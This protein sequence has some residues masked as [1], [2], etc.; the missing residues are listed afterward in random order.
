[1]I[2]ARTAKQDH[3][4]GELT[5]GIARG[6]FDVAAYIGYLGISLLLVFE[7][8]NKPMDLDLAIAAHKQAVSLTP[9]DHPDKSRRLNSLGLSR[10]RR[11][12]TL[13]DIIDLDG[14]IAAQRRAMY[15]APDG[16]PDKPGCL[17]NLG[18]S[19]LRRFER[20]GDIGD[21]CEAIVN[22]Q[23]AVKLTPDGHPDKPQRINN[24]GNSFLL[25][26]ERLGDIRDL[27]EAIRT[28]QQAVQLTPDGHPDKPQRIN[29]LR[30]SFLDR[31]GRLVDVDDIDEAIRTRRQADQLTPD[32]HSAKQLSWTTT[33][34]VDGVDAEA[35][36]SQDRAKFL[37]RRDIM[38]LIPR[39]IK[40]FIIHPGDN[41]QIRGFEELFV[42]LE[43]TSAASEL[44][45]LVEAYF[46]E[47]PAL[48]LHLSMSP[49]LPGIAFESCNNFV[50]AFSG[51]F[52]IAKEYSLAAGLLREMT[53]VTSWDQSVSRFRPPVQVNVDLI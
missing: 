36:L 17:N 51:S 43:I 42:Y 23:Q 31:F 49:A 27:D 20:L 46:A 14:A 44:R 21:I 25:R 15:L 40:R 48:Q 24:L 16:H 50:G 4:I 22:Q 12:E 32:G 3:N 45:R 9:D 7:I 6:L 26:F 18:N 19:F 10:H 11:F 38:V 53:A 34:F 39:H 28:Q 47:S 33:T 1:M 52:H 13:G 37:K 41:G 30:N 5:E 35:D 2:F 8:L 29:N